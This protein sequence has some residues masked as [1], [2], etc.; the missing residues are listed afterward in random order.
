MTRIAVLSGAG[1]SAESGIQ[2]FRDAKGLWEGHRIEE[3][4]TPEAFEINP[5]RVLAFYNQRRRQLLQC[6]PNAAHRILAE[7][8]S[9]F[10]VHIVTQNVDDLHERAGSSHV[11]HLHGEL[12]KVRSTGYPELVYTW[13]RD[14][15]I[16]DCCERGC[17]LRPHIV[18][19]GEE[20]PNIGEASEII[21]GA[22]VLIVIGTSL[23]VHPAAGLLYFIRQGAEIVYIDPMPGQ[24]RATGLGAPVRILAMGAS[25]G[26]ELLKREWLEKNGTEA[27][28]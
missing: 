27:K 2:T 11:L 23:L 12:L 20:V 22:D 9:A 14:L 6:I 7:F 13:T 8:E 26:M 16:G 10:D 21:A 17:Q 28:D 5:A 19:F 1:I 24:L 3:V 15:V 25:E 4:A 18:W